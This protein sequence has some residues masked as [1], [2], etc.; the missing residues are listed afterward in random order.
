MN[1]IIT[2]GK[3]TKEKEKERTKVHTKDHTQKCTHLP[4]KEI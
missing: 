4:P 3:G 1:R 2:L